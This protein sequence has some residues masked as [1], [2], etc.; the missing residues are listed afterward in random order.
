MDALRTYG[1]TPGEPPWKLFVID[2]WHLK[3]ERG[4]NSDGDHWGLTYSTEVLPHGLQISIFV[5]HPDED[6]AL[7]EALDAS[8]NDMDEERARKG[9]QMLLDH[10]APMMS[11]EGGAC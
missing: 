1:L 11:Q 4:N 2:G 3:I 8:F 5:G 10:A 7:C 6:G 9:L